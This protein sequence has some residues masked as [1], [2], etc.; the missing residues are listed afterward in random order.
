MKRRTS[1]VAA[2]VVF[3]RPGDYSDKGM[4]E[5]AAWLR[6]VARDVQRYRRGG[7]LGKRFRATY[8]SVKP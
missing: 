8:H 4:R 3:H 2:S 1:D 7:K 5:I 6:R